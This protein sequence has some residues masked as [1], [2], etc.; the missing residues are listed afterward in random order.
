[1]QQSHRAGENARIPDRPP[2]ECPVAMPD[3]VGI[4]DLMIG[5]PM[6]DKKKVY[7]YLMR[8]IHDEETNGE[9]TFPAEYIFKEVPDENEEGA[10]PIDTTFVAMDKWGIQAGLFGLGD[11]AREARRR[12]P[13]RVFTSLEVDPN[14][15]M[16]TVRKIRRAKE[17]DD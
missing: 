6:R 9:F 7:E 2:Q 17:Q 4:V 11:D 1:M 14:D 16:K 3:G 10:D 12:Y 8:G 15:V 5:F 13:G